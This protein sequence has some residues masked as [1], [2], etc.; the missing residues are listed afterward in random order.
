MKTIFWQKENN[1]FQWNLIT[2]SCFLNHTVSYQAPPTGETKNPSE[3]IL[4]WLKLFQ[5]PVI[6]QSH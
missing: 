1:I 4:T 6:V 3:K 5:F 2:V